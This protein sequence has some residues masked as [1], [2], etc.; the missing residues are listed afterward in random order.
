MPLAPVVSTRPIMPPESADAE[1]DGVAAGAEF[2]AELLNLVG[3]EHQ[4][5]P[6]AE[7]A[8]P[9]LAGELLDLVFALAKAPLASSSV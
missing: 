9:A 4:A 5:R 7:L 6:V 8:E 3:L 1:V 2:G